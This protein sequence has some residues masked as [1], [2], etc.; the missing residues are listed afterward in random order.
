MVFDETRGY[1]HINISPSLQITHLAQESTT[2]K[3]N[4]YKSQQLVTKGY[5]I[6]KNVHSSTSSLKSFLPC[7]VLT[8]QLL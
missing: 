1:P 7:Y 4:S 2:L 6:W 5:N 8:I 3:E